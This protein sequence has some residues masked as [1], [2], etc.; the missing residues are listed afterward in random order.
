VEALNPGV[1]TFAVSA[2]TGE[3][4]SAWTDWLVNQ[5]KDSSTMDTQEGA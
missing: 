2:K 4:M 5:V 1:V 3:G